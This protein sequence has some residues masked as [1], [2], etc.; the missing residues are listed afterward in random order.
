M[1]SPGSPT[2]PSSA[3]RTRCSARYR[4]RSWCPARAGWIPKQLLAACRDRLSPFK[5]PERTVRDRTGSPHGVRQDHPARAARPSCPAAGHEQRALRVAVPARLDAAAVRALGAVPGD[6]RPGDRVV[7]SGRRI[8]RGCRRRG[9]A[10]RRIR[11]E[12][13][14]RL[15]GRGS[16]RHPPAGGGDAT[17]GRRDGRRGRSGSGARRA[18]GPGPIDPGRSPRAGRRGGQRRRPP[19]GRRVRGR[20]HL[21]RAAAGAARRRRVHAETGT[22]STRPT[23]RC[24]RSTRVARSC[25]PV[26]AVRGVPPWPGIW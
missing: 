1:R 11:R 16:P 2:S 12:Q 23:R 8:G 20:G 15:A 14:G 5:V 6:R 24:P 10:R 19:V 13:G 4:S 22:G 21:G 18:V 25:S 17:C 26:Q 3:N 9:T 7:R